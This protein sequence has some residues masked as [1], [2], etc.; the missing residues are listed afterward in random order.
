MF[1]NPLISRLFAA[2]LLLSSSSASVAASKNQDVWVSV[3]NRLEGPEGNVTVPGARFL[4][5]LH[6]YREQDGGGV[7]FLATD[8]GE[9]G[10]ALFKIEDET[11][12]TKVFE[13]NTATYFESVVYSP[14]S[15]N[16]Y[17]T[18]PST[19]SIIRL[20]SDGESSVIFHD[21]SKNPAG[22]AIDYCTS[23][24][25]WSNTQRGGAT[26][27]AWSETEGG[28]Q[29]D[30]IDS[31][32]VISDGLTRPRGI[33][34]D[35]AAG[36][37]YW[38]DQARNKFSI[39]RSE[40]DGSGRFLVAEGLGGEPF[41]LGVTESLI[42]WSDWA[43]RA[44]WRIHKHADHSAEL[45]RMYELS[46]PSGVAYV[47]NQINCERNAATLPAIPEDSS[48]VPESAS[49]STATVSSSST[50]SAELEFKTDI[51]VHPAYKESYSIQA[52]VTDTNASRI[53]LEGS[54]DE[55]GA[56]LCNEGWRGNF[57][58]VSVCENYCLEGNCEVVEGN[59]LCICASSYSG[60]RCEI[61]SSSSCTEGFLPVQMMNY[62]ILILPIL[63]TLQ[64]IV[65]I[66]LST[67]FI[68]Y[69]R[70]PRIVRKRFISVSNKGLKAKNKD[71]KSCSG[72]GGLP[73][74]DGIQLDIE[75][76]CNMTLCDTPC[77]EPA[78]RAPRGR[79]GSIYSPKKSGKSDKQSLL[80]DDN[81]DDDLY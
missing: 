72:G 13:D 20:N 36:H 32:V 11:N 24:I 33:A 77:F 41:S 52:S 40:L 44:T 3:S 42:Y 62:L 63:I 61:S 67:A 45:V 27:E 66:A 59:P 16:I 78:N 26:V 7:V 22:L 8:V 25:Y 31:R 5:G 49:S 76:C 75:N 29:P 58:Q 47:P 79:S 69:K 65:I 55:E 38:T 14:R 70:Q 48:S 74:D 81:G 15:R 37:L 10:A 54:L 28:P 60:D 39:W 53:C 34:V 43:R 6:G 18:S 12:I 71:T 64:F 23:T 56:C 2:S 21:E 46:K 68:R 50:E 4:T 30:K 1:G 80:A 17:L 35:L 51:P 9:N 19:H 57:C 73:T